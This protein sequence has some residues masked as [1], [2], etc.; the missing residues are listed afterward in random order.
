MIEDLCIEVDKSG[1]K[2]MGF[3]KPSAT[4]PQFVGG[5]ADTGSCIM[6]IGP[7]LVKRLGVKRSELINLSMDVKEVNGT[8]MEVIGRIPVKLGLNLGNRGKMMET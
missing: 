3:P 2:I 8:S 1:Y 4:H 6:V 7:E 5:I